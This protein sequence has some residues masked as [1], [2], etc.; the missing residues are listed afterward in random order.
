L[1]TNPA[2]R[3]FRIY[4]W[5]LY[6]WPNIRSF[7]CSGPSHPSLG[8]EAVQIHGAD[9]KALIGNMGKINAYF[10]NWVEGIAGTSKM[11]ENWCSRRE[12]W[13]EKARHGSAGRE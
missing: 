10:M 1:L 6:G 12:R 13:N 5:S 3:Q 9:L 4:R 11:P 8:K 7:P 2:K